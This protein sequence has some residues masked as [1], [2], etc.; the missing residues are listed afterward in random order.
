MHEKIIHPK[1]ECSEE[2]GKIIAPKRMPIYICT[3][4]EAILIIPDL[5]AMNEAI[6]A[7]LIKHRKST[8]Q[9]LKEDNLAQEIL[10]TIGEQNHP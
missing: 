4:G 3:C 6:K 10:K 5:P 7:H 1:S 2:T 8:G 9:V